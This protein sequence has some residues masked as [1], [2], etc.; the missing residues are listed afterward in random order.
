MG[1]TKAAK[2]LWVLAFLL[3]AAAAAEPVVAKDL[4]NMARKSATALESFPLLVQILVVVVG[5]IK[6]LM[7]FYKFKRMQDN[8]QQQSFMGAVVTGLVGV[9]MIF[10]PSAVEMLGGTLDLQSGGNLTRPRMQ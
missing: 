1:S 9:A 10:F 7:G 2:G 5:G 8:P 3:L 4:G 6:E